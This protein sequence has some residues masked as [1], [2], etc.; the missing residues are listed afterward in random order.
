MHIKVWLPWFGLRS[1]SRKS[2][3]STEI[4]KKRKQSKP[5]KRS[6]K[7]K[8]D[9]F[10]PEIFRLNVD[11][12][13]EIC[14]WLS[15]NDLNAFGQTCK[16]MKSIVSEYIERN[17]SAMN[18]ILRKDRIEAFSST[19]ARIVFPQIIKKI[20]IVASQL[21]DERL[22]YI[23]SNC[24]SLEQIQFKFTTITVPNIE[25]IRPI[26]QNIQ[27]VRF[28][29][30]TIHGDFYGDFLRYCDKLRV[31]SVRSGEGILIGMNNEWMLRQYPHLKYLEMSQINGAKIDELQTFFD[32][33]PQIETLG[34]NS[35]LLR[36]NQSTFVETSK[37]FKDLAIIMNYVASR[38]Y[39]SFFNLLNE[40]HR[41]GFYQRLHLYMFSFNEETL[42]ELSSVRGFV[43]LY[44]ANARISCR[45]V[46]SPMLNM[47]E[48]SIDGSENLID[49]E[50]LARNL[51]NLQRI[52]FYRANYEDILP[53]FRHSVRL[54]KIKV[55]QM[56]ISQQSD[57]VIL[58]L[59]TLNAERE[60]LAN[61]LKVIIYVK[62][63]LF[64]QTKYATDTINLS[65]VE[66][67]LVESFQW[68]QH[69][70]N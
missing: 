7:C 56:K 65:R 50:L 51:K 3:N 45:R 58:D 38:D 6:K 43:K 63:K 25:C 31:L 12:V 59:R 26:L 23:A 29:K 1:K 70:L 5:K 28:V 54:K 34:V 36:A 55:R 22:K 69:F 52:F 32:S 21:D 53:F 44:S 46:L 66:M 2:T 47:S 9:D 17:Y 24:T 8:S 13:Q 15:L 57:N 27:V 48:L 41:K 11:C 4:M 60:K 19:K 14:E 10:V 39:P 33:N 67:R 16:A 61:A 35:S 49:I 20:L 30:A 42:C 18:T 64:L 40:L 68:H 62:E 37:Q